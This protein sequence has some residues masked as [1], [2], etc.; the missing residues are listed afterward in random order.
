MYY[1]QKLFSP[2]QLTNASLFSARSFIHMQYWLLSM[3]VTVPHPCLRT[4]IL[5]G[6][7]CTA[8]HSVC[9]SSQPC[10]THTLPWVTHLLCEIWHDI[11]GG[12]GSREFVCV[13]SWISASLGICDPLGGFIECIRMHVQRQR[14]SM[15]WACGLKCESVC[16]GEGDCFRQ[17]LKCNRLRHVACSVS[18]C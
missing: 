8:E 14:E 12:C 6:S 11:F 7:P 3:C 10:V 9:E 16:D 18:C 1:I 4:V 15:I 13:Y 17:V 2:T 5:Q